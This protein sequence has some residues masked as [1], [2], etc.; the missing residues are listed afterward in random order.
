MRKFEVTVNNIDF[1]NGID[2]IK[3]LSDGRITGSDTDILEIMLAE[4]FLF[5]NRIF[6][7]KEL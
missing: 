4:A 2:S 5:E 7:V 3:D 6:S 1:E